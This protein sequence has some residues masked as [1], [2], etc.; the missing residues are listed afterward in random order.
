[1]EDNRSIASSIASGR[2][3]IDR[4][5]LDTFTSNPTS[6]TSTRD[7]SAT[8]DWSSGGPHLDANGE[9]VDNDPGDT[10][11]PNPMTP[12]TRKLG[13]ADVAALIINKMIGTGIFAGP[14]TVLINSPSKSVAMGLWVLGLCYTVSR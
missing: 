1:M 9:G 11:V 6:I 5:R 3:S 10:G 12:L 2:S 8:F 13:R 4:Y 7:D 14:Y